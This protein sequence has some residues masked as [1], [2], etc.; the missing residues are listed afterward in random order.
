[1]PTATPPPDGSTPAR[2]QRGSWNDLPIATRLTLAFAAVSL[3]VAVSGALGVAA[4][5]RLRHSL[6][7]MYNDYTVGATHLSGAA[8]GLARYRN[9]VFVGM[10][11]RSEDGFREVTKAQPELREHILAHLEDYGRGRTFRTSRTTS[12][13]TRPR[14]P[15]TSRPRN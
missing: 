1:M 10:V 2:P 9:N 11:A 3:V 12:T 15:I 6:T 13:A 7:A 5:G 8:S 14:S 4:F